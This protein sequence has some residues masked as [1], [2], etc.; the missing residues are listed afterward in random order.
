M[1]IK[2]NELKKYQELDNIISLISF[3]LFQLSSFQKTNISFQKT[4]KEILNNLKIE[5]ILFDNTHYTNYSKDLY[6][7]KNNRMLLGLIK[8]DK[9]HYLVFFNKFQKNSFI[10]YIEIFYIYD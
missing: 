4:I 6:L 7:L 3:I 2:I 10:K 9:K 5:L 1:K 8:K